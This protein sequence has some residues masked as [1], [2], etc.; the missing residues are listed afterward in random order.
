M[1]DT[2]VSILFY[3]SIAAT[4]GCLLGWLCGEQIARRACAEAMVRGL[5]QRLEQASSKT[6]R[7][8][9][10]TEMRHVLNDAHKHIVAVSK[11]LKNQPR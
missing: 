2:I 4:L 6:P 3:I 10:L 1:S 9:Q 7:D 5:R 8:L 11:G